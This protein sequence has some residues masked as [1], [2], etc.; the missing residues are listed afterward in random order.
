[1]DLS[2]A[3]NAEIRRVRATAESIARKPLTLSAN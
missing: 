3:D 1:M 2:V